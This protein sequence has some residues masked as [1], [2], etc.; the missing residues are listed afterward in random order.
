M[1]HT[2]KHGQYKKQITSLRYGKYTSDKLEAV[3]NV[4]ISTLTIR[5]N[6][7]KQN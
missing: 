2:R 5:K 3:R 7:R 1:R 6:I 4:K